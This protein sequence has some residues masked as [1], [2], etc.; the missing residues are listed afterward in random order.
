MDFAS[1][2]QFAWLLLAI[3]IVLLYYFALGRKRR[4]L[5]TISLWQRALARRTAWS[6]WRRLVSLLVVLAALG[7][8]VLAAARPNFSAG[9]GARNLV[10]VL[11]NS[12]SMQAR[13]VSPSRFLRGKQDA[14]RI[15]AS[16]GIHDRAAI[17]STGSLTRV[18]CTLTADHLVLEHALENVLPTDGRSRVAEAVAAARRLLQHKPNGEIIVIT[19]A[20]FDDPQLAAAEDVR[21]IV[22]RGEGQNVAITRFE[23]RPNAQLGRYDC[24]VEVAN[25]GSEARDVVFRVE[26]R[27]TDEPVFTGGSLSLEADASQ[28]LFSSFAGTEGDLVSAVLEVDDALPA[29]NVARCMAPPQP[30]IPVAILGTPSVSLPEA[31]A[32]V[33]GRYTRAESAAD[34]AITIINQ[35]AQ[36]ASLPEGPLVV[37]APT[38]DAEGFWTYKGRMASG[39]AVAALTASGA[40]ASLCDELAD[41]VIGEPVMLEYQTPAQ[42]MLGSRSGQPLVTVIERDAGRIV[43]VHLAVDDGDLADHA[44][45]PLLLARLLDVATKDVAAMDGAAKDDVENGE[46]PSTLD[47]ATTVSFQGSLESVRLP[48]RRVRGA[49]KQSPAF[50][51][52]DEVGP[53]EVRTGGDE[54]EAVL[55]ANLL[56]RRESDIDAAAE[57]TS[58]PWNEPPQARIPLWVYFAIAALMLVAADWTL[59]RRGVL[60]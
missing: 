51:T 19:D 41:V 45:L 43:V 23:V 2:H 29:D 15:L 5:S 40:L 54:A 20:C 42:V 31:L 48:Q 27:S 26:A 17:L 46:P 60:E 4:E 49:D 37:F 21:W 10:I 12:A 44:V 52:L 57:V 18:H 7:L 35:P 50:A 16:L 9:G 56:D 25:L 58:R 33:G 39:D 47:T 38:A 14:E 24:L 28:T 32:A 3:P 36:I 11:D 13:D 59:Y 1:P 22:H 30:S 8:L 55:L 34:E 6:K 53:W